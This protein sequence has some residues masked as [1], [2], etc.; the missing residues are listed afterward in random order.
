LD[1]AA[2]QREVEVKGFLVAR[3]VAGK[4]G[5]L[6]MRHDI[7]GLA[8]QMRGMSLSG[9]VEQ[10]E[11]GSSVNVCSEKAGAAVKFVEEF[12][13]RC[14]N[15]K[16]IPHAL[17]VA[18]KDYRGVK[19]MGNLP[20][21]RQGLQACLTMLSGAFPDLNLELHDHLVTE[22]STGWL[23]AS[24]MVWTGTHSANFMGQPP[25]WQAITVKGFMVHKVKIE[26]TKFTLVESYMTR[27]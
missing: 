27:P 8:F 21:D 16:D 22:V 19:P 11:K 6:Y 10:L 1:I 17:A 24:R 18:S 15:K 25:T 12:V 3:I 20:E 5:E 23:V 26:D 9:P 13:E 2:A 14:F 4:I 7:E